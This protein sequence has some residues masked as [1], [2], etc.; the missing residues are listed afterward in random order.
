MAF[1]SPKE[2]E[3][4]LEVQLARV[5]AG[6]PLWLRKT[7]SPSNSKLTV[8][9]NY[10]ADLS[11]RDEDVCRAFLFKSP[12]DTD[13]ASYAVKKFLALGAPIV[14]YVFSDGKEKS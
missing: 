12:T 2:K 8:P 5:Q 14:M 7:K 6:H 13:V 4:S 11:I 9:K 1:Q 3:L 10:A